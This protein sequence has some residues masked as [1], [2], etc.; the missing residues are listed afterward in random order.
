MFIKMFAF[1]D[2]A[3]VFTKVN[4][5]PSVSKKLTEEHFR[6]TFAPMSKLIQDELLDMYKW[7]E[8]YGYYG[9]AK[10]WTTGRKLTHLNTYG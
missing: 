2:L 10:D 4:G 3:E 8:K 9:K 5:V 6:S 1:E 7:F